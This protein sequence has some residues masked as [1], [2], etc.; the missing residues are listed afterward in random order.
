MTH[1]SFDNIVSGGFYIPF[2][3]PLFRP[4][5]HKGLGILLCLD[6]VDA[7]DSVV[8]KSPIV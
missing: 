5:Y 8:Y 4:N 1:P 3:R 7:V 2:P 6:V